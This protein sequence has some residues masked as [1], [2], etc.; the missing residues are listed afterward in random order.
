MWQIHTCVREIECVS[1]PQF[2]CHLLPPCSAPLG[3]V[4]GNTLTE[5][6]GQQDRIS[7]RQKCQQPV[8]GLLS[9]WNQ[10]SSYFPHCFT[11]RNGERRQ[12]GPLFTFCVTSWFQL[13]K[14]FVY[15]YVTPTPHTHSDIHPSSNPVLFYCIHFKEFPVLWPH[16]S[17]CRMINSHQL[18]PNNRLK[19]HYSLLR[20]HCFCGNL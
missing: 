20:T 1:G 13:S 5:E 19:W 6:P 10:F 8:L 18:F 15:F 16:L 14:V 3:P 11:I 12:K 9:P 2:A 17:N 7:F 4:C